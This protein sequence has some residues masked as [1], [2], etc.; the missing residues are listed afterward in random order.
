MVVPFWEGMGLGI[1]IPESLSHCM[2]AA[3]ERRRCFGKDGSLQIK[4]SSKKF[5]NCKLS[6]NNLLKSWRNGSFHVKGRI[7]DAQHSISTTHGMS[8]GEK[9]K[10]KI[11]KVAYY[12]KLLLAT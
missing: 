1:Y 7:W 12:I 4:L 3:L 10:D 2:W 8:K 5:K 6:V 11:R 9:V